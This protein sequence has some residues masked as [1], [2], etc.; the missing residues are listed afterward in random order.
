MT[1]GLLHFGGFYAKT[2]C[3]FRQIVRGGGCII[4]DIIYR[5]GVWELQDGEKG[6]KEAGS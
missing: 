5:T 4:T 3:G 6:W 1:R 2:G